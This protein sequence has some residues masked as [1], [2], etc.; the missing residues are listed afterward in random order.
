[1]LAAKILIA[2]ALVFVA[3]CLV[4]A[5]M[6]SRPREPRAGRRLIGPAG[7]PWPCAGTPGFSPE[8]CEAIARRPVEQHHASDG[9]LL[10]R[11][12]AGSGKPSHPLGPLPLPANLNRRGRRAF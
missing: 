1:M 4:A 11:S 6:V 10:R 12:A 3:L 7:Q 9:E 5:V 2:I 8:Q